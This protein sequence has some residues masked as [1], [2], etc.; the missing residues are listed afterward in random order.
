MHVHNTSL[1]LSNT[2]TTDRTGRA[3]AHQSDRKHAATTR[4]TAK[5]PTVTPALREIDLTTAT[6]DKPLTV[7]GLEQAWG[8]DDPRYDLNKD[9]IVDVNDLMSLLQQLAKQEASGAAPATPET[10]VAESVAAENTEQPTDA[11]TLEGLMQAWGSD[12][13][14]Y[15]LNGDGTVDTSDL[16]SFLQQYGGQQSEAGEVIGDTSNVDP[17]SLFTNNGGDNGELSLDGLMQAWGSDDPQYDLNGD[18]TVDTSDLLSFLQ[19]YGGQSPEAGD[20]PGSTSNV[21]PATQTS[22]ADPAS[23][24]LTLDGL[25]Q[26]W[27]SDNAQYDLNGDGTVDVQDLLQMLSSLTPGETTAA[28]DISSLLSA[29]GGPSFAAQDPASLASSLIEKLEESGFDQHPPTNLHDMLGQLNLSDGDR[30]SVLE[31]LSNHYPV[32]LGVNMVG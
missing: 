22:N 13:P 30:K 31:K 19:Q 2:I 17:S 9:G 7:E 26:A 14:Q 8:T 20:G 18:G 27:G 5:T 29:N 28:S 16:L 3:E 10:G 15:D 24:N 32:G 1:S 12:D 11:P 4:A 21:D 25:M 6:A 23:N